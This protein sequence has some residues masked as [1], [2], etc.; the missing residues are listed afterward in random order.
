MDGDAFRALGLVV[1]TWLP[2]RVGARAAAGAAAG[3]GVESLRWQAVTG[4]L[5]VKDHLSDL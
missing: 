4:S 3:R 2:P 1:G 5:E